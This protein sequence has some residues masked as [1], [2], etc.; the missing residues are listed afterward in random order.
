MRAASA[1]RSASS[2]RRLRLLGA[3]ARELGERARH[4]GDD[5]VHDERHR[6][7][8][9]R[10]R[11]ASR[12]RDVEVVERRRAG[13]ARRE[14]EHEAPAGRDDQHGHQIDDRQRQDGRR[15]REREDDQRRGRH[16]H[17]R[18]DRARVARRDPCPAGVPAPESCRPY[19]TH[20][21][22]VPGASPPLLRRRHLGLRATP[23]RRTVGWCP[24]APAGWA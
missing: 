1:T 11:E 3:G 19:A 20:P 4:D 18:D 15:V 10:D 7:R 13:Q 17:E 22:G 14:A 6:I 9:A 8:R 21:G 2:R 24:S 16:Q 12:R 5:Q 23:L